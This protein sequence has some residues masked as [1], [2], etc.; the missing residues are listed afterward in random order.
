MRFS[1]QQLFD[2]KGGGSFTAPSI[3][4][5]MN[6]GATEYTLSVICSD[7]SG[8]VKPFKNELKEM[9]MNAAAATKS[10]PRS[11]NV[12]LRVMTF[13]GGR[14]EYQINE[15]HGFMPASEIDINNYPDLYPDNGTPLYKASMNAIS[16]VIDYGKTLSAENV[17]VN[18]IVY[19]ITDG[20][21]TEEGIGV[22][23]SQIAEKLREIQLIKGFDSITTILIGMTSPLP[24][25][26]QLSD[27]Q[28]QERQQMID[29]LQAFKNEANL[30]HFIDM[31]NA[32]PATLAKLANLVSSSLI[33]KSKRVGTTEDSDDM[34][35]VTAGFESETNF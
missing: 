35:D 2:I 11:E 3:N 23:K 19:I 24:D 4:Q 13:A 12:L 10:S 27:S 21:D 33:V 30:T 18:S 20:Q 28:R 31:G 26:Y 16:S 17:L 1:N 32:N 5:I 29:G 25:G 8:S 6:D 7:N 22:S 34:S 14:G 9:I 15:I